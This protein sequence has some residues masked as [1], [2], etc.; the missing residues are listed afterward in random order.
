MSLSV[1][2]AVPLDQLQ[3]II[4]DVDAAEKQVKVDKAL[5]QSALDHRFADEARRLRMASGKDTGTVSIKAGAFVVKAELGKKIDWDQGKLAAVEDHLIDIGEDVS[6]Y[7]KI[8]RKVSET[9]YTNWPKSLSS[10]FEPART[11]SP[12]LAKYK[13]EA[14]KVGK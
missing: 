2:S 11:V 9:A 5:I 8:E 13:I 7:I 1:T 4:E 10:L 12:G 14:A 6:E 3:M